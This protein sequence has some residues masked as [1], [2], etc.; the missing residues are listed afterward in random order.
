VLRNLNPQFASYPTDATLLTT[1]PARNAGV[2]LTTVASG[3]S[4]SGTSL[5]VN[6]AHGL[7]PGWAGTQGDTIRVGASTT[8]QITAID[9]STNTITLA[10]GISRAPSDPVYLYRNSSGAVVLFGS[11]PDVGA[12][13][14]GGSTP[15]APLPPTNVRI[16]R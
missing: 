9:Y 6:D 15:P 11:R 1:S 3:D 12:S 13:W 5:K 16:V 8:V 2:A 14:F 4:G 7:Q 10:S